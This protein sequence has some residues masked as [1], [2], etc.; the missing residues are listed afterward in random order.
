METLEALQSGQL[1]GI[2]RLDLAAE[3]TQFPSQ[4]LDLADSLEILN[5]TN[6]QL[7]S[8]PDEFACLQKLRI[9][10]FSNNCFEEVPS[11]L[12]HCP[13]LSMVGFKSNQITT[14]AEHALPLSV[15]WLILTDNQ[16][17]QIPPSFGQL[18]H[19]QKL[20]LAGNQLRSLPDEMAQCQNL[21][22]IRLAANQLNALP[23]WLFT[24]PRLSWLAYSGNPFCPPPSSA[25]PLAEINWAELTIQDTLGEGASGVIFK[26]CWTTAPTQTVEVAIKVFKGNITSDGLPVDEMRSRIA[27]GT[28]PHLVKLLGKISH[29][30]DQKAGLVFAFVPSTYQTLGYPPSFETCTRDTYPPDA[31]FAL[32][33]VLRIAQGIAAAAAHLHG[34]GIL[35]GDLYAHNILTNAEGESLLGDFGAASFYPDHDSATA[36][37]LERLEVRAFGCLLEDLLDRCVLDDVEAQTKLRDRLRQLQQACLNPGPAMRPPFAAICDV[38]TAID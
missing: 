5:L 11:V 6:N 12:S 37:S 19:L 34:N 15:R 27:S 25:P 17:G 29:H 20:M 22:L 28:H 23:T 24:L 14:I 18:K 30:P 2:K 10:F 35:H 9:A 21:E 16:I 31:Q 7:K 1:K 8:L 36:A 33:V 38:L 4:I 13:N 26:G 32:S 3:L